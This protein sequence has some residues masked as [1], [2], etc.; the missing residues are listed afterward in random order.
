M[1]CGDL[2]VSN[3]IDLQKKLECLRE[4]LL[5]DRECLSFLLI[6]RKEAYHCKRYCRIC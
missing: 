4:D 2:P 3:F 6:T 1:S 5:I